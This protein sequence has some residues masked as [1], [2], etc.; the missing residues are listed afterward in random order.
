MVKTYTN[1]EFNN[2]IIDSTIEVEAHSVTFMNTGEV[3]L[4][5][6]AELTLTPGDEITFGGRLESKVKQS[7]VIVFEESL[8][9][10]NLLIIVENSYKEL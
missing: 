5:I 7:F 4:T 3:N 10:T 8:L 1:Y 2:V 9:I 6:N